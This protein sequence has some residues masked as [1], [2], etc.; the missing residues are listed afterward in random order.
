MIPETYQ[1]LREMY[2]QEK[3]LHEFHVNQL[4]EQLNPLIWLAEHYIV[5]E[6]HEATD[7]SD[8]ESLKKLANSC[9]LDLDAEI[10]QIWEARKVEI[11]N[12]LNESINMH[13]ELIRGC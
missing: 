5:K 7:R 9:Y 8:I 6:A 13:I 4:V 12:D 10:E 1:E 2:T 3:K 11:Q